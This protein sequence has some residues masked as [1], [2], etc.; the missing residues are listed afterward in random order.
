MKFKQ[1]YYESISDSFQVYHGGKKWYYTPTDLIASKKNRKNYGTGIYTTNFLNT[2][3]SYAKGS[4]VVHLLEI[5]KNY[6]DI[7][8]VKIDVNEAV[9]FIK[10]LNGLRKKQQL[11]DQL[12]HY[13]EKIGKQEI[14]LSIL[15]NIIINND[16]AP[17]ILGKQVSNFLVSKGA[18]AEFISQ[19][20]NEFWLL[21][22]NPKIIKGFAV[23]DPKKEGKE[24]PF[25]LPNIKNPVN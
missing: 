6:R 21:I 18:D 4:R 14:G 25:E 8:Q 23:V 17:G 10:N 20:G 24:F 2:A 19:S 15:N 13:S 9:D 11:I 12:Q 16:A 22:F 3:R 7:R 5:D 1:F